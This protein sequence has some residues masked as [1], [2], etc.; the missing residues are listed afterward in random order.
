[1]HFFVAEGFWGAKYNSASSKAMQKGQWGQEGQVGRGGAKGNRC[2]G[3]ALRNA[4]NNQK[5]QNGLRTSGG[6]VQN[7]NSHLTPSR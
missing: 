6:R 1:M 5:K 2:G 4:G 3:V 7:I